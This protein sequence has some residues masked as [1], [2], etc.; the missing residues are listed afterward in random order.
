MS[1]PHWGDV[2]TWTASLGA[3]AAF[4]ATL[5]GLFLQ[6]RQIKGQQKQLREQSDMFGRQATL[7][8]LQTEE[9]R[10]LTNERRRDQAELVR[11]EIVSS[12][13]GLFQACVNG[14]EGRVTNL[15]AVLLDCSIKRH[16]H[17]GMYALNREA[18]GPR[19]EDI[20]ALDAWTKV[21]NEADFVLNPGCKVGFKVPDNL[22]SQAWVLGMVVCFTDSKGIRWQRS[23]TDGLVELPSGTA[24]FSI[25][26]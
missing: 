10:N 16:P 24:D 19:A 1:F 13:S 17:D 15:A 26:A 23:T 2:P 22:A 3:V 8:K 5:R 25:H 12:Q 4:G 6:Q 21:A 18:Y 9:L 20:L 7:L 14:G 11:I